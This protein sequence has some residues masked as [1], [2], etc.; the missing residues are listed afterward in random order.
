M[1]KFLD[2]PVT[3]SLDKID[4]KSRLEQTASELAATEEKTRKTNEQIK[5]FTGLFE[6][7]ASVGR[8]NAAINVSK[9][10]NE[11]NSQLHDSIVN[12]SILEQPKLIENAIASH[13]DAVAGYKA[14]VQSQFLDQKSKDRL[15]QQFAEGRIKYLG[16]A[17]KTSTMNSLRYKKAETD[18]NL[19][20]AE[21]LAFNNFGNNVSEE[22]EISNISN[23]LKAIAGTDPK[24]ADIMINSLTAAIGRGSIS[25][26][27]TGGQIPMAIEL[28]KRYRKNLSVQNIQK[29][30]KQ[31]DAALKKYGTADKAKTSADISGWK[32]LS[33]HKD[34]L[35]VTGSSMLK[36]G[37]A[38]ATGAVGMLLISGFNGVVKGSRDGQINVNSKKL[39]ED[40]VEK[41]NKNMGHIFSD[42]N[43]I[44][45][46]NMLRTYAVHLNKKKT[47]D[48]G[49]WAQEVGIPTKVLPLK[50]RDNI[51]DSLVE[52]GRK[53]GFFG[54]ELLSLFR[55]GDGNEK[56]NIA[57]FSSQLSDDLKPA[58]RVFINAQLYL[59]VNKEEKLSNRA[60]EFLQASPKNAESL[61]TILK[62]F[63]KGDQ[64]LFNHKTGLSS[65]Q[66]RLLYNGASSDMSES[67]IMLEA[68]I[69]ARERLTEEQSDL[70][71]GK[72][73]SKR[74]VRTIF[75][76]T[77]AEVAQ[78]KWNKRS[79]DIEV[80]N[81]SLI[82]ALKNAG[83]IDNR[84]FFGATS[85]IKLKENVKAS[86]SG[87]SADPHV[88]EEVVEN[89]CKE[90][91]SVGV[92]NQV[93]V[94]GVSAN[95][96]KDTGMS[97]ISKINGDGVTFTCN[98]VADSGQ[99]MSLPL[100]RNDGQPVTLSKEVVKKTLDTLPPDMSIA[101]KVNACL[102]V[103]LDNAQCE[104]Y[105][106]NGDTFR[107]V[108]STIPKIES[109]ESEATTTSKVMGAINKVKGG[110]SWG[111]N[112]FNEEKED[113]FSII[114]EVRGIAKVLSE[115]SF[116]LGT[117]SQ[118]KLAD[119]R[120]AQG[121]EATAPQGLGFCQ[122]NPK[123]WYNK[124]PKNIE[125]SLEF[126]RVYEGSDGLNVVGSCVDGEHIFSDN[127][128]NIKTLVT[129][130]KW[131]SHGKH[132]TNLEAATIAAMRYNGHTLIFDNSADTMKNW[133][134]S[135]ATLIV[136]DAKKYP[137]TG[138]SVASMAQ[139]IMHGIK[140]A[141][142]MSDANPLI[143]NTSEGHR[144][145]RKLLTKKYQLKDGV[146]MTGQEI[147]DKQYGEKQVVSIRNDIFKKRNK[148]FTERGKD[149]PT[150][151]E[152]ASASFLGDR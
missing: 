110:K 13:P 38:M 83:P 41:Y 1:P 133:F 58:D 98:T 52:H 112:D 89:M 118:V 74:D 117:F 107:Q 70:S 30:K 96:I 26:A 81:P 47:K 17:L 33:A 104:Q 77:L 102:S 106:L 16:R 15:V 144:V 111:G 35:L 71:S 56:I 64:Q 42:N 44:D 142:A 148:P 92:L 123:A 141:T 50:D 152:W 134:L 143:V 105:T 32:K 78:E 14:Q 72:V 3:T 94:D 139:N 101:D 11:S 5:A 151:D 84:Q 146:V 130:G 48:P 140:Y 21:L 108:Q 129:K 126:G 23:N 91:T 120:I 87:S 114:G 53:G 2:N 29:F 122:I 113:P 27:I 85:F 86:V 20:K 121:K 57:N 39:F 46:I 95:A 150:R 43:K 132:L 115:T 61:Y 131:A 127:V 147:V 60:F 63:N 136:R 45:M 7:A 51:Q 31:I 135:D 79:G 37:A 119:K 88:V 4:A 66:L 19:K 149:V 22:P 55:Y 116:I 18:K 124:D 97:I 75:E 6:L 40:H 65:D 9:Q 128:K 103:S 93:P 100:T 90:V 28:F 125:E 82:S 49:A 80:K 10:A 99:R 34:T 76:D 67:L 24:N 12:A 69:L 8:D 145:I 36:T 68:A 62:S 109:D 54:T 137:K 59:A 25:G 73:L 138:E